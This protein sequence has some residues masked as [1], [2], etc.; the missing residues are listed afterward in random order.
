MSSEF[1]VQPEI[2]SDIPVYSEI[3]IKRESSP[4]HVETFENQA[5]SINT[6]VNTHSKSSQQ[7]NPATPSYDDVLWTKN[8]PHK[9]KSKKDQCE[10]NLVW[11]MISVIILLLLAVGA[12]AVVTL[13]Q[14]S[15]LNTE[16][17]SLRASLSNSS[18]VLDSE[19][20]SNRGSLHLALA[21][22]SNEIVYIEA[23][24][25][26]S[27]AVL[28]QKFSTLENET[29]IHFDVLDSRV[30]GLYTIHLTGR[31]SDNPAI[32]CF[33][34]LQLNSPSP[35]GHYWIRSSNGSAVRVYCD[36]TRSCGGVTG[37]WMRV[38]SLDWSTESLPCPYGFRKRGHSN[39]HTCGIGSTLTG[40]CSSLIFKTYSTVYSRVFGAYG[41]GSSI[42][43]N[44]VD[45]VS[46][47]HGSNPRRHIWTFAAAIND[48]P[49]SS[50]SSSLCQCVKPG[51]MAPPS[52]VGA[53]YFCDTGS[54]SGARDGQLYPDDPLW[55]G[56][57]CASTSTCCS[58][59]NPP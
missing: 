11:I 53:D 44:Y 3:N 59:N 35:S 34:V 42:D 41:R 5:Y 29:Q 21:E 45:G 58:F 13:I 31:N 16:I 27:S 23:S 24:L 28:S 17:V 32:S 2:P 40:S 30:N 49:N 52:F 36:M 43:S 8:A 25:S 57:G 22:V 56:A 48:N 55:D 26:N 50:H 37:G 18:A 12:V 54:R 38:V 46:L 1:D 19:I 15:K 14:V 10:R 47:T 33:H 9:E 20:L 51:I 4:P 7:A 6:L 39:I